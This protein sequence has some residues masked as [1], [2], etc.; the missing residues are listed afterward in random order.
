[1]QPFEFYASRADY[2]RFVSVYMRVVSPGGETA[3]YVN[4]LA[5]SDPQP[6]DAFVSEPTFQ[7]DQRSAQRLMDE[8]WHCGV[9]PAKDVGSV[10]QLA[11]TERHL[12]DMR[13]M[14][15]KAYDPEFK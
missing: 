4:A 14:V 2:G 10:G 6:L 5:L 11:A 8:L 9:R 13:A 15:K 7:L 1:M 3:R 12:E